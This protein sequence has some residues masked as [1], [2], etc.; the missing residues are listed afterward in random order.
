MKAVALSGGVMLHDVMSDHESSHLVTG[1]AVGGFGPLLAAG[2]LS[3]WRDRA[4]GTN[5]ALV[6]VVVVVIAATIG[7]WVAG[8]VGAV[9]SALSFDFFHTA[10]YLSLSI[11]ERHELETTVLLLVVGV[12]VG[13][14]AGWGRRQR[15][16]VV[17]RRGEEVGRFVIDADPRVGIDRDRRVSAVLIADHAAAALTQPA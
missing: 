11:S 16:V 4:N 1:V 17:V 2:V 8:S 5:V 15:A 7:G 9:V 13:V 3:P 6:L 12:L 14:V 10:P